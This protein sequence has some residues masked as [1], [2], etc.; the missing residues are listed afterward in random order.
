M[1][2]EKCIWIGFIWI[3][4]IE[5]FDS[6]SRYTYSNGFVGCFFFISTIPSIS[7]LLAPYF[8]QIYDRQQLLLA[9][10]SPLRFANVSDLHSFSPPKCQ[11]DLDCECVCLCIGV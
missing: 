4:H 11:I 5:S 2:I 8:L 10:N 6:C 3:F 9:L 7:L 1:R